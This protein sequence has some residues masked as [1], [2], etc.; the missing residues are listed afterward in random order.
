MG[1]N[2]QLRKSYH[3]PALHHRQVRRATDKVRESTQS[4]LDGAIKLRQCL[5]ASRG[6]HSPYGGAAGG[7][8]VHPLKP[9]AF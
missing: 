4:T 6:A 1:V 5:E 7:E 2:S 3:Y 9:P 8:S